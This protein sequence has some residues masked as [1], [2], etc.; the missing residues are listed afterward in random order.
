[1][2]LRS[3]AVGAVAL[4]VLTGGCSTGSDSSASKKPSVVTCPASA[5]TSATPDKI[6]DL[7]VQDLLARSLAALCFAPGVRISG[8]NG[9]EK[10]PFSLDMTY[11]SAGSTGTFTAG[12][13]ELQLREIAQVIYVK[14][15]DQF[16][17]QQLAANPL[18][19]PKIKGKWVAGPPDNKIT[20]D[21]AG[22][23]ELHAFAGSLFGGTGGVTKG[24]TS[25]IDGI[26][27]IALEDKDGT[28]FVGT[29]DGRP[30]LLTG[31]GDDAGS[32]IAITG[33]GTA[34]VL[35]VPPAEDT[36]PAADLVK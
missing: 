21:L 17:K 12:G 35:E 22:V 23:T 24:A 18:A 32:R 13:Y 30:V 4:A 29:A 8:A 6:A 28:L 11:S 19:L 34:P 10:S 1:M 36:V 7:A 27:V 3:V 14:G 26:E 2:R 5:P 33:Y 25:T 16:W 15:P 9:S 20:R 31:K